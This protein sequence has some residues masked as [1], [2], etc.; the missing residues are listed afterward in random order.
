M[1]FSKLWPVGLI[2][3]NS[4]VRSAEPPSDCV[5]CDVAGLRALVYGIE[6]SS[7]CGKSLSSR[8]VSSD[9]PRESCSFWASFGFSRIKEVCMREEPSSVPTSCNISL[10]N[11]FTDGF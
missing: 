4:A 5:G 9:L 11:G 10:S 3:V 1:R 6:E 7:I 2:V 8:H